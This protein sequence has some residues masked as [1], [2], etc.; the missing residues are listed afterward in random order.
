MSQRE[1]LPRKKYTH[2][3]K[4]TVSLGKFVHFPATND[5]FVSLYATYIKGLE[6]K[7]VFAFPEQQQQ[8]PQSSPITSVSPVSQHAKPVHYTSEQTIFP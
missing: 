8:N 3:E 7:M 5:S 4:N 1:I 2:T 6:Y